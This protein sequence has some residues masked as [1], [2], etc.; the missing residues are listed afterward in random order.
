MMPRPIRYA[1]YVLSFVVSFLFFAYWMFPM[2]AVKGRI[3]TSAEQALGPEYVVQIG[4]IKTHWLS[5][6]RLENFTVSRLQQG[7]EEMVLEAGRVTARAGLF[8][9]IFGNPKIGFDLRME[10]MR[11][12]GTIRRSEGGWGL[13]AS[14]ANVDLSRIPWLRQKLGLSLVSSIDGNVQLNYDA[15]Q[16]LRTAGRMEFSTDLLSLKGGDLPL[17]DMGTFPLPDLSLASKNSQFRAAV[18]KGAINLETLRLK[19]EDLHL[20]LAGKIFLA[21]SVD[22]YRMNLQGK[23]QFSP[24]VWDAVD[25]LLPEKWF[26]ELKKQKTPDDTFPL[27]ISGQLASPQIYSGAVAVVPFNPF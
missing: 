7:K 8:S 27:S 12:H 15:K 26:S 5:G 1:L 4:K 25:P 10:K 3:I 11:A 20:E 19:G 21:P 14:L 23:I 9:L 6:V 17:G 18:E 13:D 16:P 24:K 22:R 2:E